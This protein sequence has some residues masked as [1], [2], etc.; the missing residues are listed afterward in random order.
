MKTFDASVLYRCSFCVSSCVKYTTQ[1]T[2]IL[3]HQRIIAALG[4]KSK[5]NLRKLYIDPAMEKGLVV[6][7][8]PDKPTSRNQTYI[9]LG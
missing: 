2:L 9:R 4:F 8:M 7:G 1:I 6:M 3:C 5:E